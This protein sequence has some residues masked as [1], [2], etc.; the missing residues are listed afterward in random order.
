MALTCYYMSIYDLD[1]VYATSF[2]GYDNQANMSKN[3]IILKPFRDTS[4]KPKPYNFQD[5]QEFRN[6]ERKTRPLQITKN[7]KYYGEIAGNVW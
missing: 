2:V 1:S 7:Y 4:R 5:R 3:K 6:L